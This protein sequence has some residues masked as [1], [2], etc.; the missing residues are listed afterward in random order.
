MQLSA[1]KAMKAHHGDRV[2]IKT[3]E[4]CYD[5]ILMPRPGLLEEGFTIL[6]LDNGYN[7]GISN[8]RI[9][10]VDVLEQ[11]KAPEQQKRELKFN[12][13]LPT[14]SILSFGGTISSKVDYRTGGTYADYTAEDFVQ[15]MPELEKVANLK[16]KKI[17]GMMSE[18]MGPDDW[19][20]IAEAVLH[21]VNDKNVVGVVVTH[22]TDTLHFSSAAVSFFLKNLTKPV[23]F[24]AAQRSI[25]R[26]SSDAFVNLLC[27]IHAA[28]SDIAEVMT[29]LHGSTND[30]YCLLIRGTKVRKMHASRRD[31]FRPIN[32]LPLGKI[33][34]DGTLTIM[35]QNRK[36]RNE[37][38]VSIQHDVEKKVALVYTYPGI[39]PEVL[40]IFIE[41]KYKG[42]VIAGTGLGHVPT[43]SKLSLIPKIRKFIES[44]GFVVIGSQT[45]YGRVHPS[46]YSGLRE[47]STIGCVFCEDMPPEVTYVKLMWALGQKKGIGDVKKLMLAN[48][49][50]EITER[51]DAGSFLI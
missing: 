16:A 44:G 13:K 42:L 39:D 33:D 7:I 8:E 43:Y 12:P 47:L 51:S 34:V 5:G 48:V 40:D 20:L 32:E 3:A 35:N 26:G 1:L 38:V 9:E 49:A 21:E 50:G 10:K 31:A 45:I 19:K 30:E 28:K 36:K 4:Q 24:T 27:A 17:A 15:M 18:D 29:C 25:D 2:R 46:V 37:G 41:K 14:V 6:K 22:G 11:Y 23:V